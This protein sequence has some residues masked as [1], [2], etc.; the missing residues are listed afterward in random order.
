MKYTQKTK[1]QRGF[2][3]VELLVVIAIIAALAAMASPAI[4]KALE[5][6]RQT[7]ALATCK[8]LENA[9]N[10]FENEYSYLPY[11]SNGEYPSSDTSTGQPL[12]TERGGILRVLAGYDTSVNSRGIAYY[13]P[14]QQAKA[15][16]DGAEVTGSGDNQDIDLWDPWGNFYNMYLDYDLDGQIDNPH[17]GKV[18]SGEKFRYVTGFKVLV[19]SIGPD[20]EANTRNDVVNW[21]VN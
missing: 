9:V 18:D 16:K 15:E 12:K 8:D 1:L 17:Y 19:Q 6:G 20:D 7:K 10:S 3:L 21:K 13:S 4:L 14:T 11:P 2:T 5:K